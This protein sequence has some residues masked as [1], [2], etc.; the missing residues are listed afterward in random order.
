VDAARFLA[1]SC[2]FCFSP[3]LSFS[4]HLPVTVP[5]EPQLFQW[6]M[7]AADSYG[8]PVQYLANTAESVFLSPPRD[9]SGF[10]P[11]SGG[12]WLGPRPH[13]R[14]RNAFPVV[15]RSQTFEQ[16]ALAAGDEGTSVFVWACLELVSPSARR[17]LRI[18][19]RPRRPGGNEPG[20]PQFLPQSTTR[21]RKAHKTFAVPR[22]Y[23]DSP[24]P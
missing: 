8:G 12:A 16:V 11:M 23:V 7:A 17:N 3:G 4:G 20:Q 15:Q 2:C 18:R 22:P 1:G 14:R 21:W 9:R 10:A 6:G 5:N 24:C 13:F 19:G